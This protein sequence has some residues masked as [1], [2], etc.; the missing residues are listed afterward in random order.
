M[1]TRMVVLSML[2][3][4]A[5]SCG[6]KKKS[7]SS[8]PVRPE[9]V[10]QKTLVKLMDDVTKTFDPNGYNADDLLKDKKEGTLTDL[11]AKKVQQSIDE[12][13]KIRKPSDAC[14]AKNDSTSQVYG[15]E[16]IKG[17]K[18]KFPKKA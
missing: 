17:L 15:E 14:R 4:A 2:G 18:A 6:G 16:Y 13:A 3:L 7:K 1:I 5:V 11:G 9:A 12:M 10:C 8:G